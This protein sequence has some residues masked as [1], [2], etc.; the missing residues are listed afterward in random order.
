MIEITPQDRYNNRISKRQL[1]KNRKAK[2]K[3]QRREF[4]DT[5]EL[6]DIESMYP[7]Y[8]KDIEDADITRDTFEETAEELAD[9]RPYHTYLVTF[10]VL[11]TPLLKMVNNKKIYKR[12]HLIV[13]ARGFKEAR[14]IVRAKYDNKYLDDGGI[15]NI[16]TTILTNEQMELYRSSN[17]DNQT[18]I[19]NNLITETEL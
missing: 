15:G 3:K 12:E 10:K 13:E 11:V 17:K 16:S 19:M 9:E 14:D 18:E 6:D 1:A 2:E 4:M 8:F 5:L 7:N